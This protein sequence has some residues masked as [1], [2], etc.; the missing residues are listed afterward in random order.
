MK[1]EVSGLPAACMLFV[2]TAGVVSAQT[3]APQS[4]SS[5]AVPSSQNAPAEVDQQVRAVQQQLLDASR[6]DDKD[7]ARRLMADDLTWVMPSG[8]LLTRDEMLEGKPMPPKSI[9][10]EHVQALGNTAVSTGSA[11]FPDGHEVRFLQEWTNRAGRWQ[12]LAH[13]ATAVGAATAANPAPTPPTPAGTS[14]AGAMRPSPPTLTSDED[15]AVWK[16]QNDLQ[17][18]FLEGNTKAYAALTSDTYVRI[19]AD[20]TQWDK[21]QL[22]QFVK[23]N[24]GKSAGHLETSDVH[25]TVMGDTARLVMNTFGTLPGGQA[26]RPAR[27]TRVFVK[28]NGTWQQAATIFT[29][30]ARE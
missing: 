24:E 12:L 26:A 13:Q 21:H 23:G 2:L 19:N 3:T 10:V 27:T 5:Q 20:G 14:G 22:L 9:S 17:R 11:V 16:A 4:S 28:R 6:A 25:L 30:I 7:T 8:R 18:A 1:R 29:P 15:R